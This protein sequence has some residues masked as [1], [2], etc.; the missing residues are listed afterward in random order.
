MQIEDIMDKNICVLCT[1]ESARIKFLEYCEDNGL[2]FIG[3]GPCVEVGLSRSRYFP[4]R[5]TAFYLTDGQVQI[6]DGRSPYIRR[7]FRI[8]YFKDFFKGKNTVPSL[9]PSDMSIEELLGMA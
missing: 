7:R 9:K 5:D 2:S 8:V 3:G 1:T 4:Q 6:T